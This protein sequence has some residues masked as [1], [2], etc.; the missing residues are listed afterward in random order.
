M[1][2]Q[3]PFASIAQPAQGNPLP[4][5]MQSGSDPFASIAKAPD[6]VPGFWDTLK[7]EGKALTGTISGMPAAIYHAFSEPATKEELEQLGPSSPLAAKAESPN[8]KA[9][10]QMGL[11]IYRMTAAPL[12]VAGKYYWDAAHGKYG[13]ASAV[14]SAMLNA[15]P[16]AIGQAGGTAIAGKVASTAGDIVKGVPAGDAI[17]AVRPKPTLNN[18]TA[19][20]DLSIPATD[21]AAAAVR[22]SVKAT[23]TVLAKAP[24]TVGA[25]T[26]AAIGH[27][28][29]VPYGGEVGAIIGGGIGREVLPKVQIPGEGFG[30]PNRVEGGPASAPAYQPPVEPQPIYPGAPQPEANPEAVQGNALLKPGASP[31]PEPASALGNLPPAPQSPAQRLPSAFQPLPAKPPA[32]PGTV[33]APF[34]P[35]TEL[36]IP[37]VNQA[38]SELGMSA[39]LSALTERANNIAKLGDLLN[40]GLGG[41]ELEPNVPLKNQGNGGIVPKANGAIPEGHTAVDSSAVKS[42]KYDPAVKELDITTPGGGRYVYGEIS[43]DQAEAFGKGE[44]QGKGAKD[45]PSIG[46]AWKDVRNS[47]GVVLLQKNVNGKL[48]PVTPQINPE[49]QISPEE[50]QAGHE[51]GTQVE[52]S[53]R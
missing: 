38:I 22:G 28:T 20:P 16:E 15:A 43:P 52:G 40:Q 37:A 53:P 41:K 8:A 33:E 30:L 9:A 24:G 3:D 49:D 23:N 27:A 35:L 39:P 5:S 25:A 44:Y 36:P 11:G 4:A 31:S 13:D 2:P 14:E 21:T 32:V 6:A 10:Q 34:K 12:E 7:R 1:P 46:K 17:L 19:G 45:T 29:G 48:V 50:W 47:P 26:G 18:P 42:Y 51:L